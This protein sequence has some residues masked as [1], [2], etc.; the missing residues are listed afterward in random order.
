MSECVS[1][2]VSELVVNDVGMHAHTCVCACALSERYVFQ[3]YRKVYRF[4]IV[5]REC[6]YATHENSHIC[7]TIIHK[8][9]VKISPGIFFSLIL[10]PLESIVNTQ[11]TDLQSHGT[12]C[13]CQIKFHGTQCLLLIWTP[14][15]L[16]FEGMKTVCYMLAMY[17]NRIRCRV[18]LR[19]MF[20][21]RVLLWFVTSQFNSYRI[22]VTLFSMRKWIIYPTWTNNHNI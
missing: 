5:A 19:I 14:C 2:W 12:T 16:R 9:L 15:W 7:E 1:E 6:L 4:S 11:N 13:F 18:N 22:E 21:A 8:E 10:R 3:Q 20:T 17:R